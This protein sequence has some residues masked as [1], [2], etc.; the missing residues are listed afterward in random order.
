ML[1][2]GLES[3]FPEL[4]T[5]NRKTTRISGDPSAKW[6]L[7]MTWLSKS[8]SEEPGPEFLAVDGRVSALGSEVAQSICVKV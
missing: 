4:F 8:A 5:E 7:K 3:Y 1:G 6:K 2:L